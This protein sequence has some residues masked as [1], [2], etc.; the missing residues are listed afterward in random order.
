M[1]V[2]FIP[3]WNNT[4]YWLSVAICPTSC[5]VSC[6]FLE[7]KKWFRSHCHVA[8]SGIERYQFQ[9]SIPP[10]WNLVLAV[11]IPGTWYCPALLPFCHKSH[12]KSGCVWVW[13]C[14]SSYPQ[15]YT[16]F[17]SALHWMHVSVH[18]LEATCLPHWTIVTTFKVCELL[19]S[20]AVV[21]MCA[22]TILHCR[23]KWLIP[24][25]RREAAQIVMWGTPGGEARHLTLD[26]RWRDRSIKVGDVWIIVSCLSNSV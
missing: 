8:V 12:C 7:I 11:M 13:R 9:N 24:L 23:G 2:F 14:T 16:L 20:P 22:H 18:S 17:I 5:I 15:L 26:R 1:H 19:S 25:A 6:I 4:C 3:F 21:V 10:S